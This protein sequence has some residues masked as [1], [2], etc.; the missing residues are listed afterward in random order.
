MG[1][2]PAPRRS[3]VTDYTIEH[4]I[5]QHAGGNAALDAVMKGLAD[6][7]E[8]IFLALV[9][10][11]FVYGWWT[12][13]R[14]DRVGAV[15]AVV[16]AAGALGVNQLISAAW[17]RPR[18]YAAH[19]AVNV[20]LDRS[21]DPS[22]PSDHAAAAFAIAVVAVLVCRRL[23]LLALLLAVLISYARVYVGLHYPGDVLGGA[24][25]GLVVA[26]VVMRPLRVVPEK[27]TDL[28]DF[29]LARVPWL[30]RA[31]VA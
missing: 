17:N 31:R 29:V 11:W 14:V 18:P 22:F 1:H 19:S 30:P 23:G 20:L 9:A 25:V 28:C 15:A 16:A 5:N 10:A 4:W 21:S 24:A 2:A 26:V 3:T 7:A 27:L 8:V 12:R 6:G 13:R